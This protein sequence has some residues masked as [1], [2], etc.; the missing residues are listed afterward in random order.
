MT[1]PIASDLVERLRHV[2]RGPNGGWNRLANPDGPEAA[3]AITQLQND[4]RELREALKPFVLACD[5]CEGDDHPS[6][7]IWEHPAAMNICINDLRRAREALA[8]GTTD[9]T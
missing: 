5:D 8:K 6:A 1:S 9:A 4:N 3:A 2:H 7:S